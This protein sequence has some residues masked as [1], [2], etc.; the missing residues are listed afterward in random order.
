MSVMMSTAADSVL[1]P[2]RGRY[3][4]DGWMLFA[5]ISLLSIGYVMVVSA[6]LHLGDR[7]DRKSVV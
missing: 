7:I 4:L 6:S 2:R 3:Y 1:A 5:A